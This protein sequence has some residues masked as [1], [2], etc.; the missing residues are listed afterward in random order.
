MKS[1]SYYYIVD[2]V[3]ETVQGSFIA[4]N[5]AMAFRNFGT[6]IKSLPENASSEDFYL[7]EGSSFEICESFSEV[8]DISTMNN[9]IYGDT[10]DGSIK[11]VKND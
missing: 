1:V 10:L 5:R 8:N 11:K 7:V 3:S 2:S 6:F 9:T 4:V